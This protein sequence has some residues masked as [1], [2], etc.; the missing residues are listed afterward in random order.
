MPAPIPSTSMLEPGGML[1]ITPYVPALM[2]EA[3]DEPVVKRLIGLTP[4]IEIRT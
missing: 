2:M 4:G 3:C 1:R